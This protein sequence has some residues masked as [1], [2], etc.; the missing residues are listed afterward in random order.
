M[1]FFIHKVDLSLEFSNDFGVLFLVVLH[2]KL[3]VVREVFV[4]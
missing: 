3:I 1:V 2:G 4:A